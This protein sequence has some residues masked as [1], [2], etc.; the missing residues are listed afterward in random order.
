M[1]LRCS[2][3]RWVADDPQPGLVEIAFTDADGRIHRFVEKCSVV[4]ADNRLHRSA[5]FP[6][7][8]QVA[9]R[10]H[11]QDFRPAVEVHYP[12]VDLTP[13]GVSHEGE[14]FAVERGSLTWGE[15]A[16][17]SDLSVAARQAVGLVTFRR[18][19]ERVG[20]ELSDLAA[21]EEHL[22]AFSAVTPDTF[23]AWFEAHPL[24]RL[25]MSDPLPE[26]LSRAAMHRGVNPARLRRAIDSLMAITYGGLFGGLESSWSLRDLQSLGEVT[27]RDGVP[28]VEP[29]GFAGSLWVDDDWGRPSAAVVNQWRSRS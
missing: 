13:W 12:C 17:Y 26:S 5:A 15:P 1:F 28:L 16:D 6:V 19:R 3:T 14:L 23:N 11:H 18:W 22:W 2:A 24:T 27:C 4:D 25:G 21:L 9:C 20:L 8:V 10:P 29:G 7:E